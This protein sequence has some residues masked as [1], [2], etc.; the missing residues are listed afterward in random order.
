MTRRLSAA[1]FGLLCFAGA[2]V[3]FLAGTALLE[4]VR[5]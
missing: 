3:L 1:L 4:S 2:A 5:W